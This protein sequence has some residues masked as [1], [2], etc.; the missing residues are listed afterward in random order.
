MSPEKI[1]IRRE[2]IFLGTCFQAEFIKPS[3]GE[4][5]DFC[6]VFIVLPQLEKKVASLKDEIGETNSELKTLLQWQGRGNQEEGNLVALLRSDIEHSKE[7]RFVQLWL[8]NA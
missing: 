5:V 6:C 8:H 7:E 2:I 3:L 1:S 4:I